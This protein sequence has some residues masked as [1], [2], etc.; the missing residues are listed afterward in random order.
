[1]HK[2]IFALL[3][4]IFIFHFST[5]AQDK[6]F[7]AGIILGEP[8][9]FSGKYWLSSS[10]AVDFALAYSFIGKHSAFSIH[11]DYLYHQFDIFHTQ[12]RIVLYYGF[13]GR[14]RLV[15]NDKNGLGARGV[16]GLAWLSNKFPADVFFDFA[17]VF[18]LLPT[19]A[20]NL[21]LAIGA[22]FYFD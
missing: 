3:S 13:G 16:V 19:T 7:G 8:T 12:E 9:G 5:N 17:P 20:L 14:L 4:F 18:T 22:R 1:M 10:N 6:G 2:N 21:D 15:N 11:A